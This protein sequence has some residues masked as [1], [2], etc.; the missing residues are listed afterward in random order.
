[1]PPPSRGAARRWLAVSLLLLMAVQL[2]ASSVDWTNRCA[3]LGCNCRWVQGK[4]AA[5]CERISAIP[6]LSSE[7]Q[8]LNVSYNEITYIH[9]N[10]FE[11]VG[12]VN[13]HKLFMRG[14]N[15]T[16]IDPGAFNGLEIVIEID[17]SN[18]QISKLDHRTFHE[19]HRLRLLYLS[20]NPIEQ[21]EDGLFRNHSFLQTV[22]LENNRIHTIGP[23]TFQNTP[24]LQRLKL[25]GNRLT[26]L[27][28]NTVSQMTKLKSLGL[29]NNPWR[30]DC[31]MRPLRDW[32]TERNLNT[33]PTH[34]LEPERLKD[35]LWS[36]IASNEF[37]CPPR[38]A[39]AS[40]S[41]AASTGGNV[42]LSCR[43]TGDP[44]PSIDWVYNS[45][46][47][48]NASRAAH[49]GY[50]QHYAV[51]RRESRHG[52]E[53]WA[54]LTVINVRTSDSGRYTCAARNPGGIEE[55]F[56]YLAVSESAGG[57]IAGAST[58][59]LYVWF[60]SLMVA[61]LVLLVLVLLLCYC[62]CR[63]KASRQRHRT[64]MLKKHPHEQISS[65]GDLLSGEDEQE[66]A[67]IT[68][69][70]PLQKPPRR[71]ESAQSSVNGSQTTDL[72]RS[73]LIIEDGGVTGNGGTT[74][75]LRTRTSEGAVSYDSLLDADEFT[76]SKSRQ[77]AEMLPMRPVVAGRPDLLAFQ[78]PAG[79]DSPAGS[80]TSTAPDNSRLP[81]QLLPP[82]GLILQPP[83]HLTGF[84]TL[85]YARS[86][87]PF[88]VH[89]M[90]GSCGSL[91]ILGGATAIRRPPYPHGA[92]DNLGR[93]T[94]VDGSSNASLNTSGVATPTR[95]Q[96]RPLPAT[97]TSTLPKYY[98]PIEEIE[99]SPTPVRRPPPDGDDQHGAGGAT[100]SPASEEAPLL[101]PDAPVSPAEPAS[102]KK[103]VPPKVPPKPAKR[104]AAAA[105]EPLF[106]DAEEGEDGTEV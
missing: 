74:G 17:L 57:F 24:A 5:D 9:K 18:N 43:A 20:N 81:S 96:M 87:S 39:L 10:A 100:L 22:E 85:P 53:M 46:V 63:R 67:L 60:V 1:M 14:C 66:K 89:P 54:N 13:L 88:S 31:K 50:Q 97:P 78:Q 68:K 26:F 75:T 23:K 93:R 44:Q 3:E 27:K 72:N 45:L 40:S 70:N 7:I 94:T 104:V 71:I 21:L 37:A 102:V 34:C 79:H 95:G 8:V 76:P 48:G 105:N 16:V 4:K 65:N 90:M 52:T 6:E 38:L 58:G 19:N 28:L 11:E 12:L 82:G 2:T 42:T 84:G 51:Q 49:S 98:A 91:P 30:C 32:V 64:Q 103:K 77:A 25:E 83:P 92:H 101:T 86:Q 35:K 80:S 62:L 47:L 36:E 15:I 69:I 99:P 73:H 55:V 41:V 29:A 33:Q 61:A 106:E 59:D 56:V